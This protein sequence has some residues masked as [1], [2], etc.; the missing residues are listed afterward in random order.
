MSS[1]F[2]LRKLAFIRYLYTTAVEQSRLPE[3]LSASSILTFHDSVELFLQLICIKLE[4]SKDDLDFMSYWKKL[5]S[6]LPNNANLGKEE[7]M[8]LLNKARTQL[9]HQMTMPSKDAIE[10][11]RFNV[12]AF[13]QEYT[14]LIFGIEFDNVSMSNF[15]QYMPARDNLNQAGVLMNEGKFEDA[16]DLIALAFPMIIDDYENRKRSKYGQS[17]F[18]FGKSLTFHSSLSMNISD[19]K[20]KEFV[21]IV[22]SSIESMQ[23]AIKVLSLGLDYRRYSKFHLLTPIITKTLTGYTRAS[24]IREKSLTI[25]DCI[26]CYNFVIESAIRIQDFDFDAEE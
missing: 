2:M 18:F 19:K 16:L 24:N 3:P 21:D 11:A 1:E 7:E 9:K 26:F 10:S 12:T 17:P 5:V 15:V 23:E 14:S 22:K 25:E 6:K 8:R 4:V 13:F 20:M